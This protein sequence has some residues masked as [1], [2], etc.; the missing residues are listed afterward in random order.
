LSGGGYGRVEHID[1]HRLRWRTVELHGYRARW[2]RLVAKKLVLRFVNPYQNAAH[3]GGQVQVYAPALCQCIAANLEPYGT[4]AAGASDE[5]LD[6]RVHD[7]IHGR[8]KKFEHGYI[9][10]FNADVDA[11]CHF[12]FSFSF[13][14]W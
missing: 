3:A 5:R 12:F 11:R 13:S 8:S 1:T 4:A 2:A 6:A 9:P 14:F 10:K 7:D